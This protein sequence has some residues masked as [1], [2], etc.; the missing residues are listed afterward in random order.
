MQNY[1]WG[2]NEEH[3]PVIC[4]LLYLLSSYKSKIPF[5]CGY[6]NVQCVRMFACVSYWVVTIIIDGQTLY[7]K[8]SILP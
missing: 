7:K 2:L 8:D 1:R 4:A 5:I 3:A 6:I